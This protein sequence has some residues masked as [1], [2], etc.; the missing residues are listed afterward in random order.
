MFVVMLDVCPK[1]KVDV[2]RR[3]GLIKTPLI[4]CR[5]CGH[6]MRVTAKAVRNNWQ[7]N[8]V[9]VAML[10]AW[11]VLACVVLLDPKSATRL[12][13]GL[14]KFKGLQ[15]P[16][17]LAILSF[18]PAF[19]IALPFAAVGRIF[20][21]RAASRILSE[22]SR[23]PTADQLFSSQF[24]P[25]PTSRGRDL[26][27]ERWMAAPRTAPPSP[28]HEAPPGGS[29]IGTFFLRVVFGVLWTVGFIVVG[30]ISISATAMALESGDKEARQKAIEAASRAGA[31]PL[32]FGSI[33]LVVVLA[34]LGWLPGFR[35]RKA[36]A[37]AEDALLPHSKAPDSRLLAGR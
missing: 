33:L 23:E 8:F 17:T 7:Y 27:S 5:K 31:L 11:A 22:P 26:Q 25:G 30:S 4:T 24:S 9:I 34:L 6:E 3:F 13:P 15:A 1:C 32:F 2:S 36:A 21:M 35:R 18:V 19:L 12:A 28:K 20:G 29:G 14:A 37:P 16:W 10:I